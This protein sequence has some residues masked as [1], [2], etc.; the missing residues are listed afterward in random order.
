MPFNEPQT[1]RKDK[2]IVWTKTV[3]KSADIELASV[4]KQERSSAPRRRSRRK[5]GKRKKKSLLD[6]HTIY[7]EKFVA[8]RFIYQ[9]GGK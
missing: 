1:V 6:T 2:N 4:P 7:L 8:L 5:K 3:I 9:H